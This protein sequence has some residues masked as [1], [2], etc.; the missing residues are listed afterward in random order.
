M[1]A[2][3]TSQGGASDAGAQGIDKVQLATVALLVEAAQ[4]DAEFGAEE[5][6]KI[7]DLVEG[8]F[9]LSAEEGRALLQAASEK[10]EQAVEVFGFTREIKN[11]FSP[12]ERIEMMEMLWEVAYADGVLHDLEASLMRRLAGLLHVSD[13][14][15]GLARKRVIARLAPE[16]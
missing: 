3:L 14:D 15:S 8:R 16:A 2:F 13:R 11:A 4:M 6:A 9:G 12:E 1:K 7:A 5:R 10:I